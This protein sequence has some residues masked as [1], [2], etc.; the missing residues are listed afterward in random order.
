MS[1]V[2]SILR[3]DRGPHFPNVIIRNNLAQVKCRPE[4]YTHLQCLTSEIVGEKTSLPEQ[5]LKFH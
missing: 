1:Q 4:K 3:Y 2:L 5:N